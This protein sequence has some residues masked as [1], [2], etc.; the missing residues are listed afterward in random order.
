MVVSLGNAEIGAKGNVAVACGPASDESWFTDKFRPLTWRCDT[1]GS[2][3]KPSSRVIISLGLLPFSKLPKHCTTDAMM[4]IPF[5]P[6]TGQD[7]SSLLHT[8]I[9]P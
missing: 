2:S 3:K 1:L 9:A 4:A 6:V 5:G 7:T 8:L